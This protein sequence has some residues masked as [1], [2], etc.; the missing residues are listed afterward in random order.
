MYGLVVAKGFTCMCELAIVA[1]VYLCTGMNGSW[2]VIV[3]K[4]VYLCTCMY[5]SSEK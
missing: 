4:E 3:V 2:E 5:G 1:K